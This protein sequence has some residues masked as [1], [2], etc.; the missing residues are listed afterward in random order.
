MVTFTWYIMLPFSFCIWRN[1]IFTVCIS[2]C[3]RQSCILLFLSDTLTENSS[4]RAQISQNENKAQRRKKS[5]N[6][7][8]W[9]TSSFFPHPASQLSS[10]HWMIKCTFMV[11]I[12]IYMLRTL[13]PLFTEHS[14]VFPVKI[15]WHLYKWMYLVLTTKWIQLQLSSEASLRSSSSHFLTQR[16]TLPASQFPNAETAKPP[17]TPHISRQSLIY[18]YYLPCISQTFWTHSYNSCQDPQF[19]LRWLVQQLWNSPFI[20]L[21]SFF[22][23][24]THI[25]E[26]ARE[27][28]FQGHFCLW[29][30]VWA[31]ST[32]MFATYDKES[33]KSFNHLFRKKKRQTSS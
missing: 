16:M 21:A 25:T 9:W 29:F 23:S 3:Q 26:E 24:V 20:H 22:I 11:L 19:M 15:Y 14:P 5:L 6:L 27:V 28:I 17:L 13:I 18:T 33:G 12:L 7:N 2:L 10:S 8:W 1:L 4:Q 30:Q 32:K 31:L